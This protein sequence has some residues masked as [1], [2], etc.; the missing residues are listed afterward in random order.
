MGLGASRAR[1]AG[2]D[3]AEAHQ[4]QVQS[5]DAPPLYRAATFMMR[6]LAVLHRKHAARRR[7]HSGFLPLWTD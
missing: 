1:Y 7:G 3:W 4:K 6:K 5:D 2:E